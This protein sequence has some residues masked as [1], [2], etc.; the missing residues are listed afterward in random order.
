MDSVHNLRESP[1]LFFDYY[2][3]RLFE[4]DRPGYPLATDA[5]L[6]PLGNTDDTFEFP[7]IPEETEMKK[8]FEDLRAHGFEG[9]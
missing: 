7:K 3:R 4:G 5:G 6:G 8:V 1:S 9:L 2:S